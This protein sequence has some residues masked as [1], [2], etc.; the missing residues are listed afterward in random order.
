MRTDPQVACVLV[1]W[2]GWPLTERC[3]RTLEAQV[4]RALT[5]I[6]VDNGSSDETVERLR[7]EFPEVVC[8]KQGTNAGFAKACNVGA[9]FALANGAEFVWFL[10]NDTEAPATTLSKLLA[11]AGLDPRAGIVGAVLRYLHDPG[12]VQAWAGGTISLL[13]GYNRH[14]TTAAEFHGCRYITFA[15]AL[16]RRETFLEM[17]GLWEEISMYFEDS[18]FSLR[19]VRAG[20]RLAVAEDTAVL[21]AEGGSAQDGRRRASRLQQMQTRSG[22]LFLRRHGALP[23]LPVAVFLLLRVGKRIVNRD[24]AGLGAVLRGAAEGLRVPTRRVR[25]GTRV[26][27]RDV[28]A[29]GLP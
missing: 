1:T 15:S 21:H 17:G 22:V 19:A 8:L 20:W 3:L 4:Y 13:S 25:Q 18:D 6:V 28:A 23:W 10:N 27:R 2:N 26:R 11:T 12:R 14:A 24:W 7:A 16:V 5:V 9:R 29:P